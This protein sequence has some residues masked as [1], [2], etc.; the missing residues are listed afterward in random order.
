MS[1]I[2]VQNHI[3][4]DY[5]GEIVLYLTISFPVLVGDEIEQ[6]EISGIKVQESEDKSDVWVSMP[7][8][9]SKSKKK[10]PIVTNS[11]GL[12]EAIR[13]VCLRYYDDNA[14]S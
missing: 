13:K 10:Y 9:E 8:Y 2:H 11:K 5:D 12:R 6:M 14:N 1:G 3:K 7:K 4:K